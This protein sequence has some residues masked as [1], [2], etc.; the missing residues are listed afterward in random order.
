MLTC[1][2]TESAWLLLTSG[3]ERCNCAPL[4]MRVLQ[5]S[6]AMCA[7][8]GAGNAF[9]SFRVP[10][11]GIKVLQAAHGRCIE[12]AAL[13]AMRILIS[14]SAKSSSTLQRVSEVGSCMVQAMAL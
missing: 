2:I 5:S 8:C 13:L 7:C 4:Q 14:K 1:T 10:A 11:V 12:D 3:T 6:V 9:V